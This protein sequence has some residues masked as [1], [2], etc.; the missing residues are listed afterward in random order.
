METTRKIKINRYFAT[1]IAIVLL[2][3][4]TNSWG[5]FSIGGGLSS[6]FEYGKSAGFGLNIVGEVPRNN[7]VT[8]TGS[9]SYIFPRVQSRELSGSGLPAIAKDINTSPQNIT[10]PI[11]QEESINYFI[12]QA[13][14]RFYILNGFDEGFSL[15]GG[16]LV[17]FTFSK[18]KWNT[19][20]RYDDS[21]YT[22]DSTLLSQWSNRD[23]GS[24]LR[25]QVAFNGGMKYTIPNV[26]SFFFDA[27]ISLTLLP[28]V[29]NDAMPSPLYQS[30]FFNA[31]IGFRKELY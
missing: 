31:N 15:Y 5:Q 22:I 30:V 24:I 26:G 21:K 25:I 19:S 28:M 14:Q 17:G 12:A 4:S 20:P 13:G 23:Q 29:S 1:I 10:A 18:V 27:G 2:L 6:V 8:F 11:F 7:D 16:T 9:I 3:C